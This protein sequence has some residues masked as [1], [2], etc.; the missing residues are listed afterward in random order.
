MK[1]LHLRHHKA[2]PAPQGAPDQPRIVV[3]AGYHPDNVEV[4]LDDP[5]RITFHREDDSAC[6]EHVVFADLGVT[7]FLPLNEDVTIELHPERAGDY[8]FTCGM[9]MLR[10]HVTV[11]PD[12]GSERPNNREHP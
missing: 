3:H 2:S 12:A 10:G 11:L 1:T 9:G 6:S 7:A 4:E 5:I 8:P